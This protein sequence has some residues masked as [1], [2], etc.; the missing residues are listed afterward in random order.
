MN[1]LGIHDGHN[2]TV[3]LFQGDQVTY[4]LSEERLSR[5]KNDGGFPGRALD[6][7]FAETMLAPRDIARVLFTSNAPSVAGWRDR[8]AVLERY[9]ATVRPET[10]MD[11]VPHRRFVRAARATASRLLGGTARVA[12]KTHAAREAR[13]QPL[14]DRGFAV[15]QI[16]TMDH[17]MS[18]AVSAYAAAHTYDVD[19]LVLTNDGGGDGSCATV[20]IGRGGRLERLLSI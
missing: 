1:I 10:L 19:V 8:D 13:L 16:G 7:V 4:A 15:E 14:F 18:H 12:A 5:K 3:A 17:H 9:A 11:L 20:S 2:A 6:R